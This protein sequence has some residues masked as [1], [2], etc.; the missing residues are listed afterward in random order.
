MLTV[1]TTALANIYWNSVR[2][3]TLISTHGKRPILKWSPDSAIWH[4][5]QLNTQYSVNLH[6]ICTTKRSWKDLHFEG[7]IS[8]PP[9]IQ[10]LI[11]HPLQLLEP[12][13]FVLFR[14]S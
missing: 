1:E 11:Y 10:V 13:F 14:P 2:W 4:K 6:E 7:I 8:D 9:P 12:F 5:M 3:S